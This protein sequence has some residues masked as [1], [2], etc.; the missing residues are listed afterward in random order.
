MNFIFL[1]PSYDIFWIIQ[2][3][4]GINQN[5]DNKYFMEKQILYFHM[6]LKF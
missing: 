5:M 2:E 6:L 4:K 1:L 3:H